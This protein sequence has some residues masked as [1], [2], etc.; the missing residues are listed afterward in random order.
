MGD[1]VFPA[2]FEAFHKRKLIAIRSYE[3]GEVKRPFQILKDGYAPVRKAVSASSNCVVHLR[4]DASFVQ[5]IAICLAA[6]FAE[7]EFELISGE[8]PFRSPVPTNA[9]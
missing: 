6:N 5:K 2:F 7:G 9:R 8:R 4:R 1:F 3:Y